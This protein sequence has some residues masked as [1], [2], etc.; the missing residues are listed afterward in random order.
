MIINEVLQI[1]NEKIT[2]TK[3]R[4]VLI[5][6]VVRRGRDMKLNEFKDLVELRTKIAS[7]IPYTLGLL[8]TIYN[9]GKIDI[10]TSLVFFLSMIAIDMA[11]TAINNYTDFKHSKH[12]EGYNFKVHNVITRES[13]NLKTIKVVII[14][15]LL[16][17]AVMG[18]YLVT[19]TDYIVLL[20]GIMGFAIGVSY[21]FG[22]IPISRTPLGE[23]IS[24]ILMGGA[25][26][27]TSIYINTLDVQMISINFIFSR[28]I[29][30]IMIVDILKII[31][32]SIPLIIMISNIMLANNLCD[33]ESDLENNR[34]TLP[35]FIG[36]ENAIRL[37]KIGYIL[38]YLIVL[39]NY[40]LGIYPSAALL[41]LISMPKVF[42][43]TK[44]FAMMQTKKDTFKLSVN[45]FTLISITLI[46]GF[47]CQILIDRIG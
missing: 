44:S 32:A 30:N 9:Y 5:S 4:I 34:Y 6:Q 14:L 39:L 40:G 31:S 36:K 29:V 7:V 35:I 38:V 17:G 28:M 13:L 46:I 20:I 27:F 21:S 42:K 15:L 2:V 43:N 33:M 41:A 25:I 1:K 11:T 3:F 37:F 23:I 24:G 47:V 26:F 22:P 10:K 45:N 12:R 16:I 18:L 19:L 8:Y